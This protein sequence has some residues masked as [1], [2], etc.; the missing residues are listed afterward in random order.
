MTKRSGLEMEKIGAIL[1]DAN[2]KAASLALTPNTNAGLQTSAP[3]PLVTEFHQLAKLMRD[4]G[5]QEWEILILRIAQDKR[6]SISPEVMPY[7]RAKLKNYPDL[8]V[9]HALMLYKGEFFPQVDQ[10]IELIEGQR[11]LKYLGK[12]NAEWSTWKTRQ[13]E[14]EQEGR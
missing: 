3:S 9:R 11:E 10:I 12:I 7:W 5:A 4:R 2:P 8:E 13:K 1:K 6:H 14:A